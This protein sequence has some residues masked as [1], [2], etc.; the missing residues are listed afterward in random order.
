MIN[1][2]KEIPP[3]IMDPDD[4]LLS[5]SHPSKILVRTYN[6]D[7]S[8]KS[9][10]IDDS[11]FIRDVLFVLVHKNHREPDLNYTLIEILPDLHMGSK[12]IFSRISLVNFEFCRTNF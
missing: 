7:G 9:I 5:Q 8:T 10:F 2:I 1:P 11:M 3:I 12:R 6:D 4:S